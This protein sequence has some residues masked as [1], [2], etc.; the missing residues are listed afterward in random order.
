MDFNELL[1]QASSMQENLKNKQEKLDNT[2]FEVNA[3]GAIE[4]KIKGNYEIL[5]IKIDPDF[6]K[7]DVKFVEQTLL[8]AINQGLEKVKKEQEKMSSDLTSSI[9]IPGLF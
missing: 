1:K 9:N 5:D 7:E 3:N 2:V 6:L 4:L 8:S